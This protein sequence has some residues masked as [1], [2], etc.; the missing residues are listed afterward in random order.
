MATPPPRTRKPWT[1]LGTGR[2]AS[3]PPST[4]P[5]LEEVLKV[6][7]AR[8]LFIGGLPRESLTQEDLTSIF[9][10]F[11]TVEEAIALPK[12]GVGFVVFRAWA[13]AHR[14]LRALD[15]ELF[16]VGGEDVKLNIRF[17]ETSP[18]QSGD[19]WSKGLPFTRVFLGGLPADVELQEVREAAEEFGE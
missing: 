12:K 10:E 3:Q 13:E 9:S 17:A 7:D 16:D 18:G 5:S 2:A 1:A 8:K 6:L 14:A 4:A 19:F 11:G 15:G